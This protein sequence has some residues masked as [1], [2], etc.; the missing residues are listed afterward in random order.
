[1]E[2]APCLGLRSLVFSCEKSLCKLLCPAITAAL[3]FCGLGEAAFDGGGAVC[4]DLGAE[5]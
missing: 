1:M 2:L 5:V 4:C 3:F